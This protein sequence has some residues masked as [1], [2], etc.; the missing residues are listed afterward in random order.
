VVHRC[1]I[2][3]SDINATIRDRGGDGSDRSQEASEGEEGVCSNHFG[4]WLFAKICFATGK[5]E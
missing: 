2:I 4:G 5:K 3:G 1:G